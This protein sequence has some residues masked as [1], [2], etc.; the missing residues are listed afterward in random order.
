MSRIFIGVDNGVSGSVG[1]ISDE[2][3]LFFLTPV[4]L[5]TN[6]QKKAKQLNRID[7]P[8][9]IEIFKNYQELDV[10]A[11]LERPMVNP[12]RFE[13]TA[14]ALR[15]FEA[16]LI[17]LEELNISHE[18]VDSKSW[19]KQLLP[20]GLK[21]SDQQKKASMDVACRMFPQFKEDITKHKDG[22]GLLIAE[23]ARRNNL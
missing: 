1:I 18:F 3:V 23:W 17:V 7:F 4:K 12:T 21:G 13:A 10:K 19:Q 15:A 6:Y 22:D 9:L 5:C 14:S 11:I 16:T 20:E 2:Q 8:A